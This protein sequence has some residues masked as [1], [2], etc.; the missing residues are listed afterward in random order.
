MSK[1]QMIDEVDMAFASAYREIGV[2]DR[3]FDSA[4]HGSELHRLVTLQIAM[5]RVIDKEYESCS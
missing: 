1:E 5:H 3:D 4:V 2:T